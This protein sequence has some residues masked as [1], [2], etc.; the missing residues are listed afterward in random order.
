MRS[1]IA[2][3]VFEFLAIPLG[4]LITLLA[5]YIKNKV[6]EEKDKVLLRLLAV[7]GITQ[8][9]VDLWFLLSW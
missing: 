6:I 9:V 8:A 4:I 7:Y 5:I 2:H 1:E 3:K